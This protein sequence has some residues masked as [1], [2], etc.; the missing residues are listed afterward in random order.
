V[1]CAPYVAFGGGAGT[2]FV[3]VSVN[4]AAGTTTGGAGSG[5]QIFPCDG[6]N[7]R[8][9]VNVSPG[10]WQLG[11]ALA[12]WTVCGFSCDFGT[13]QIKITRA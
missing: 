12:S 10:P 1:S 2:G 7:H 3:S 8:V 11:D 5:F 9:A 13:K 6:Q 4:Q